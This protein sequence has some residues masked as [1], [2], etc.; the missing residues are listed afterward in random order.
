LG[1]RGNGEG[2][3]SRYKDGRWCG[4]YTVQ[5]ASGPK[6][7]A[8]YGKSRQDVASKLSK[9][10]TD[11]DGGLVFEAGKLT[12]GE[13]LERWLNDSVK[14][15]V[16]RST[17]A[18]YGQISRDHIAPTLGRVR[19]KA[20]TPA[21]VQGLYRAKLDSGLAPRTVQYIH[22]TLHKALK[23]ALRWGLVSRNAAEAVNAPRPIKKEI[24]P[25][26]PDQSRAL[27]EAA[28]ED[29]LRALYVL[30]VTVG[31]RQG[32]LLG[33]RWEDINLDTATLV[34]ARSLSMSGPGPTFVPP[35]T[36]KGRRNVTL[37]AQAIEA[38]R[39]HKVAQDREKATLAELW[40][41]H[42]LVFP[43]QTGKPMHPWV[44]VGGS[45][46]KLLT[47]AGL[48]KATRFH[49]L[50][51]TCATLLL[52]KGVHPKIV[53]EMLGHSSIT[54]TL[55]IYSHVLPNMQERA[56]SAM[57]NVFEGS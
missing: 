5:T 43:N 36:A 9:A 31:L 24:S 29:R 7:N 37:T 52:T 18:R 46:K 8:I 51:H 42:D 38:L 30:A 21:H 55:D 1:K 41:H 20:L 23:Q 39:D 13:Y 50:R 25:L 44:L 6:R 54:V 26:S 53:Q 57:E 11:R 47:R 12:L 33:L 32:E 56:V 45:F 4:R 28:R 19:L 16:R 15:S 27:L 2:S 22:V 14:D 49:D 3:I 10:L 34:V 48:P 17:F 40:E 35:K